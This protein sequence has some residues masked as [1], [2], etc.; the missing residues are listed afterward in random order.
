MEEII[1]VVSKFDFRNEW[2]VLFTPLILMAID[3]LTGIIKAWVNK[4]FKSAV[5]RAGLG[6][7]AGEISILIIGELFSY[8][9]KLPEI[10]M[11]LAS[12]YI[13]F[14]EFVSICENIDKLGVPIPKFVKDVI[15]N[16][17]DKLQNTG[18]GNKKGVDNDY[19]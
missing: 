14:M 12:F 19:S 11:N 8:A 13:I 17:D 1:E 4:N 7:K 18:T 15:N 9:L 2:W 6:K 16:V 10:I 5:M 3:V